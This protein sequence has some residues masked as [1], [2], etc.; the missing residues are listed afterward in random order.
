MSINGEYLLKNKQV[1]TNGV[2]RNIKII[3]FVRVNFGKL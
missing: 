2:V 1:K 3:K